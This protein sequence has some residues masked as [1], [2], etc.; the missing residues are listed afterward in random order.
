MYV[1][2]SIIFFFRTAL[3]YLYIN[4][5]ILPHK[6]MRKSL[7]PLHCNLHFG[8]AYKKPSIHFPEEQRYGGSGVSWLRYFLE[9]LSKF[10][11]P[12]HFHLMCGS[13]DELSNFLIFSLLFFSSLPAIHA[14]T[15]CWVECSYSNPI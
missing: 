10:S 5:P 1:Q 12:T 11:L 4:T 8:V 13:P 6:H 14:T 7:S 15:A 2:E 3:V 9:S